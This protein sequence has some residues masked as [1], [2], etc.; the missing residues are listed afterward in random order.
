LLAN[1]NDAG[2]RLRSL[3]SA[4]TA[5]RISIR[6]RPLALGGRRSLL[7]GAMLDDDLGAMTIV[8]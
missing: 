7:F 8:A 3:R 1:A 4:S 2:G 6:R 5:G